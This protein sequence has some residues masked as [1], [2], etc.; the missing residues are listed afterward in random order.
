MYSGITLQHFT[1]IYSP[2]ELEL[3]FFNR[4]YNGVHHSIIRHPRSRNHMPTLMVHNLDQVFCAQLQQSLTFLHIRILLPAHNMGAWN[5]DTGSRRRFI[6]REQLYRLPR[7]V[8][9]LRVFFVQRGDI[10]KFGVRG[11]RSPIADIDYSRMLDI[12]WPRRTDE[13]CEFERRAAA[14][15]EED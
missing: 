14:V 13:N 2:K 1:F 12:P 11:Y 4:P 10:I 3:G 7:A 15:L 8:F 9:L 5:V 6:P